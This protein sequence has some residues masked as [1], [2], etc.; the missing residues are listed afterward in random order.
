L[1]RFGGAFPGE[2]AFL[3]AQI[4][5]LGLARVGALLGYVASEP[6]I[7]T[8]RKCL[9]LGGLSAVTRNV[10]RITTVVTDLALLRS[11]ALAADVASAS[12]V[13]AHLAGSPATA[14]TA[15]AILGDVARL[16]ARVTDVVVSLGSSTATR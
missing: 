10:V 2:V 14:S 1:L 5:G 15:A 16:A 9:R 6:A 8:L 11:C 12:A 4:A 13:V 7:V 3:V